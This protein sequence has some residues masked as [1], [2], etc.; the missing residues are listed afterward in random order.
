MR[1]NSP[2][3]RPAAED[4]AILYSGREIGAIPGDTVASALVAARERICRQTDA[5][6]GRGLFCGMGLCSECSVVVDGTPSRLACM[7][8]V[9]DGMTID[10][11]PPRPVLAA[12]AGAAKMDETEL[13]PDVLVVGGGPAGLVAAAI[14][15]EAGLDVVLIDERLKLGGQYYKQPG[16]G[17]TIDSDHLDMQYRDGRALIER[18]R[19]S[20]AMLLAGVRV[21]GAFARDHLVAAGPDSRW[22]L[23]PRQLVLATGAYERGVPFPGWTL[24]GVMTTGAAQTLLRSHQVS[25]GDRVVVSGNGP[26]NLQVAAELSRAGVTV[27]TVAELGRPF[28]LTHARA[29]VRMGLAA[30]RLIRDGLTYLRILSRHRVPLFS[31]TAVIR[32]DGEAVVRTAT[33]ARIDR[34]GKPVAGTERIVE[35]DAVCLGYGFLPSNELARSLGCAHRVDPLSDALEVVRDAAGRTSIP[36][37]WVI[38]DGGAPL[39]AKVALAAGALCGAALVRELGGEVGD[40]VKAEARRAT[41]RHA[42]QL[43]FQRA[44]ADAYEAPLLGHRLADPE[45]VVCRCENVTLGDLHGELADGVGAAG[46]L[47][48]VTRA[49]MGKCQ[50][51]YCGP[52]LTRLASEATGDA[53]DAFSGFLS[54]API[55]PTPVGAIAAPDRTSPGRPVEERFA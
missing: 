8:P 51:R 20:G 45:T 2:G 54:Q 3:V 12:C 16:A 35:V 1:A 33:L 15:A 18:F 53:V 36:G 4:M 10:V 42:R 25:P 14:A 30:P 50:G 41:R 46:S 29:A 9:H 44:L 11:Q 47:K 7:T 37:V 49:G 40:A 52:V 28:H 27:V 24:P 31:S 22:L 48:R 17:F 21:W 39:G 5:G 13:T 43:R 38:G 6:D 19:N 32:C 34:C 26:L 23:R 55:T